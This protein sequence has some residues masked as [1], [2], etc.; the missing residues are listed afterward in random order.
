MASKLTVPK[1]QKLSL[2]LIILAI[3]YFYLQVEYD[4]GW[5]KSKVD[6]NAVQ[7]EWVKPTLI[8]KFK[9]HFGINERQFR[10]KCSTDLIKQ[11][12][13]N[14]WN[15]YSIVNNIFN[16]INATDSEI[17]YGIYKSPFSDG[18]TATILSLTYDIE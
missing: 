9:D 3:A 13:S 17:I 11:W 1:A 2:L 8:E 10:S 5:E 16:D 6:E 18:K 12:I 7:A 4:I 15:E 14:K